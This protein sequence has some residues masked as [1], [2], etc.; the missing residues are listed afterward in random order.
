VRKAER[1]IQ[2][3]KL[4]VSLLLRAEYV[5]MAMWDGHTPYVVPVNFGFEDGV[6]YFHGSRTGKKADCLR[7]CDRVCFEAVIEHTLRR[8]EKACKYTSHYKSVVGSGRASFVEDIQE[9]RRAFDII[10]RHY[11]GPEN[12]WEDAALAAIAVVRVD[13]EQLTG[14]ANPPWQGD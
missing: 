8:G 1:E 13:V 4:V 14:K 2:D 5:S 3:A 7:T 10:M 6:L 9:K 12:A 11:A